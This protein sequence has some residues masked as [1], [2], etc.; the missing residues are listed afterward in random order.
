MPVKIINRN[1]EEIFT[2]GTTDWLL[3]NVGEWQTLNLKVEA[4][5]DYIATQEQPLQIDYINR[6][7]TLLNGKNWGD[8]G[9]DNGMS[10]ILKYLYSQDTNNDGTFETV[11]PYVQTYTITNV[12]GS[13]MEVAQA[14]NVQSFDNIPTNFGNKKISEVKI[15]VDKMPEGLRFKYSHLTNENFQSTNLNSLIDGTISEF[16]KPNILNNGT[17]Q[18]MEAVGLQSG[19]SIRM[20]EVKP[21]GK[22]N[23]TD[24]VY[25]YDIKIQYM[26][27]SLF[28]DL[29]NFENMEMPSYLTG[30]GSLTDN[31]SIEFYPEWNNPNVKIKNNL[32]Q[33]ERLGNTGWFDENFN[34]LSNDFKIDSVQYFDVNGNQVDA[35]DYAT[36]T[37]VKIV[38]SGVPNL[39][40]QT[41]CGFGFAWIPSNESDYKNKETPLYRNLFVQSGSLTNGFTLN[42]LFPAVN[43]GAGINGASMDSST[44][45]FTGIN[46]KIVMEA[47]FIPNPAFFALFNKKDPSDRN[48]ILWVSV[49]DGSLG[50]NFSDRVSLLADFNSLVK[51]IP[52]A[53]EYPYIDAKFIEHPFDET[54]VGETILDGLVQDDILMRIPFRIKKDKT[55][56]FQKIEFGVEAFNIGLNDDF[57]LE[58]YEIDLTQFPTDSAGTQQFDFDQSR[59]FK[60]EPGNNKN[61]VKV[62]RE[63][64]LDTVDFYGYM[65]YFATKIRYEDWLLNQ[66][67]PPAFFNANATNNGFNNDWINYIRTNGWI[68][69]FYAKIDAVVNG[70]LLQYKNQF[71]MKFV[72]YDENQNIDTTHQYFRDSD[73][74]LLNVGTDPESGKPLGVI[75]SNEPTRIEISFDILDD[76]VWDIDKTYAVTTI[77]IDKGAGRMEMRQLSSVW[78]SETDNPLIP[79]TG[80]TKLK[81]EVDVTNKVLKTSCLVDPDLLQPGAKYRIT[82]RVGCNVDGNG[83]GEIFDPG[84][85]EFRYE[86]TYE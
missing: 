47:N 39:N 20:I 70:D 37:K 18:Q 25:E 54:N 5:V 8:Y 45:K 62:K 35:M 21:Y 13:T 28:E 36:E 66:S 38:V 57:V 74:T 11:T 51:N 73:D 67:T 84:L 68:V 22:K 53:G 10:V 46:G 48:F 15:Y 34:Q 29:S 33:T 65:A 9:F 24:N 80:E 81:M 49:A 1:Y 43:F 82:G 61:W 59:G 3:G 56:V 30:D 41:E 60:L 14:I 86:T 17:F 58:K 4:S 83:T 55:V 26:I 72:D 31:F 79:L 63:P 77:E 75:L 19:M 76:G 52:P 78:G 32:K 69:N 42:T 64:L 71:K 85:Y 50:R 7:F 40:S 2:N 23:G 27:S 12:Y 6:S 16:V 44:V